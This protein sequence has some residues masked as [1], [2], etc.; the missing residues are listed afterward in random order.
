MCILYSVICWKRRRLDDLLNTMYLDAD[1]ATSFSNCH[2]KV[3]ESSR[4]IP[5][6]RRQMQSSRGIT[7]SRYHIETTQ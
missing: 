6:A 7:N 5:N 1:Q 4:G 2:I 3:M